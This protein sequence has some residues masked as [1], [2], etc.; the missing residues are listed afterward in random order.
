M[1]IGQPLIAEYP[2]DLPQH[3]CTSCIPQALIIQV[4]AARC[5]CMLIHQFT[6]HGE[7]PVRNRFDS[8]FLRIKV[9]PEE[10]RGKLL[11]APRYCDNLRFECGKPLQWPLARVQACQTCGALLLFEGWFPLNCRIDSA[12]LVLMV[13]GGLGICRKRKDVEVHLFWKYNRYLKT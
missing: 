10:P 11:I 8:L 7:V 2:A 3:E 1:C 6:W 5:S 9:G 13:I 4:I 12:G